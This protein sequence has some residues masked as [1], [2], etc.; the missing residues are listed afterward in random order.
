MFTVGKI[1]EKYGKTYGEKELIFLLPIV[2]ITHI[3]VYF[4]FGIFPHI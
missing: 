1:Y 4:I 2:T 3:S